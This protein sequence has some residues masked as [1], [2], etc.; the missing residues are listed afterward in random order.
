MKTLWKSI[1]AAAVASLALIGAH[2]SH[3]RN[4]PFNHSYGY[5]YDRYGNAY[6]RYGNL[7]EPSYLRPDYVAPGT[8]PDLTYAERE[9]RARELEYYYMSPRERATRIEQ[10]R[11]Q[12]GD[13]DGV[14][15]HPLSKN[16][17]PG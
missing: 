9:R 3:E 15:P 10:E 11:A 13:Y 1:L 17:S 16:Y 4:G 2:A 6:D 5:S 8:N 12:R 14:T 7:V